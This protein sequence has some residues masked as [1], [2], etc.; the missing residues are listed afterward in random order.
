M[1]IKP[2]QEIF[3]I[4]EAAEYL[5]CSVY[6]IRRYVKSGKLPRLRLGG[7]RE[8]RFRREDLENLLQPDG[9]EEKLRSSVPSETPFFS[10]GSRAGRTGISDLARNHDH[11][12][13]GLEENE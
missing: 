12:L 8:L 4:S 10:V 13:Y 1:T 11:Y 5:R 7:A 6:T 3:T 9:G 2:G